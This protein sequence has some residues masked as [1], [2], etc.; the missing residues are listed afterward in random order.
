MMRRTAHHTRAWQ[1]M[2]WFA[3]LMFGAL[4][5]L[6]VIVGIRDGLSPPLFI[7]AGIGILS[8]GGW[9]LMW[10]WPELR[11]R[12]LRRMNRCLQC[13]YDRRG[14]ATNAPCPECGHTPS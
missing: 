4:I 6:P 2:K 12:R 14:L 11:D 1:W 3:T 7:R 5:M 8:G 10:W 13:E 9:A